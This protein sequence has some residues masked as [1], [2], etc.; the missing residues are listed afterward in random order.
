M[1]KFNYDRIREAI[2]N[3]VKVIDVD[4][5]YLDRKAEAL[6]QSGHKVVPLG[7]PVPPPTGWVTVNESNYSEIALKIPK[8]LPGIAIYFCVGGGINYFS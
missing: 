3:K 7:F 1:T 5:S 2:K 8:V 6:Q 4:G